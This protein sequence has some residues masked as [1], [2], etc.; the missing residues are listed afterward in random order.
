[1]LLQMQQMVFSIWHSVLGKTV[2]IPGPYWGLCTAKT[3]CLILFTAKSGFLC[4]FATKL[5]AAVT[6]T[7]SK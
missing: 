2:S 7:D 6:L 3:Y 4:G 1:M 5:K